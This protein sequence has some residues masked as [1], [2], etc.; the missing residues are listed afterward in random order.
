MRFDTNNLVEHTT[1]QPPTRGVWVELERTS[2]KFDVSQ[3]QRRHY[4]GLL[5]VEKDSSSIVLLH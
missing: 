4:W 1:L 5:L 2:V 3:L